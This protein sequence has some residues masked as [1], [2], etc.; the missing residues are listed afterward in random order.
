MRTFIAIDLTP[1]I[2]T[3]LS[4]LVRKLKPAGTNVKWVAADNYHLTLKFIG[5]TS[6]EEIEAIK[7]VLN[8]LVKRHRQF[9]IA[10]KGTGSFPQGQSRLRVIWVGVS[11][12]D[13]LLAI[14]T[15][16]DQSLKKK[17]FSADDRPF[18]PHLTIG[19]VRYPQKQEKLKAELDELSQ[20]DFG[21]MTVKEITFFQ[22]VLR[23]EGP[24]YRV[25]SR[26]YL[27]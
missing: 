8:E 6:E 25:I 19:R 14:Q 10:F 18:S 12:G 22:S 7:S 4:N 1:E 23:P 5:E 13:E 11:A 26:H 27:P 2:K 16:L 24:E 21:L 3:E 20:K 17:N 15:D 9:S